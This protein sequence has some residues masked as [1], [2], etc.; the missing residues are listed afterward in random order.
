MVPQYA[1]QRVEHVIRRLLLGGQ[2][3]APPLPEGWDSEADEVWYGYNSTQGG[4][5][6]AWARL[7][8]AEQYV[9]QVR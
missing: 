5:F 7:A 2:Q 6:S 4:T 9:G 8:M 1:P 3:L